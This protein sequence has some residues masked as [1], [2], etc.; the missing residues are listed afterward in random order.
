MRILLLSD[1][2]GNLIP[3]RKIIDSVKPDHILHLGDMRKDAKQLKEEFPHIR[4]DYV[5]GNCDMVSGPAC[6]AIVTVDG[7]RILYTHGHEHAVKMS[8][9]RLRLAALE[10]QVQV[11]AFGHTHQQY[12]EQIDG[13]WIVSP[14]SS[15][16]NANYA[17][18]EI[19]QGVASCSLH[20]L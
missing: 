8:L 17:I 20:T 19:E 18:I 16:R 15:Q 10:A 7:C 3:A 5:P 11:A 14:G 4:M 9:M 6:V 1:T 12:C 2:H 13:L